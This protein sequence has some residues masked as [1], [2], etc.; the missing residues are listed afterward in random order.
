M[1]LCICHTYAC[2]NN[3]IPFLW[4][5][6]TDLAQLEADGAEAGEQVVLANPTCGGCHQVIV[7]ITDYN[8]TPDPNTGG[9]VPADPSD[10]TT[11]D[12]V[13]AATGS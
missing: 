9:I 10:T 4:D 6:N 7:D 8:V 5:Y 11:T 12:T 1:K 2:Q 3:G 13:P